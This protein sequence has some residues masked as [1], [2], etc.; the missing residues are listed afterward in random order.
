MSLNPAPWLLKKETF[1]KLTEKYQRVQNTNSVIKPNKS[2][3]H[4]VVIIKWIIAQ[5]AKRPRSE[6]VQILKLWL[7]IIAKFSNSMVWLQRM[8]KK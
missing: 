6:T 5:E 4:A 8:P 1:K 3:G 2:R 7:F